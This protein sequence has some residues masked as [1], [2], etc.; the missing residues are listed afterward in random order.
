MMK[1]L[2]EA[3]NAARDQYGTSLAELSQRAPTLVI[4]LRHFG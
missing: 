4:F 3:L 1:D 2:T